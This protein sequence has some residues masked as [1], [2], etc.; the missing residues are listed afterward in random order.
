MLTSW[1]DKN[2]VQ[3]FH[4]RIWRF[5]GFFPLAYSTAKFGAGS[6]KVLENVAK[7]LAAPG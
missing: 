6:P 1:F 2:G 3:L 5:D 4:F 7:S